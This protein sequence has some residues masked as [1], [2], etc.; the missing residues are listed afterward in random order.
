MSEFWWRDDPETARIVA[1]YR[2][3]DSERAM[4]GWPQCARC[5]RHVNRIEA[6][7]LCKSCYQ[8]IKYQERKAD[9]E[10]QTA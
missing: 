7:G 10:N 4:R 9:R 2:S 3:G 8:R 5:K 6:K 1:D